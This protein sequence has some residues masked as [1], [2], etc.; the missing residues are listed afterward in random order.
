MNTKPLLTLL[1]GLVLF[2]AGWILGQLNPND[3]HA[4][5]PPPEAAPFYDPPRLYCR[6]FQVPLKGLSSAFET[7]DRTTEIGQWIE[8]EEQSY[9]LFSIDFEIGQKPTGYAE[10]WVQIC[11]SPRKS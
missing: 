1:I 11:L 3:A 2:Q 10:G 7:N 6:P 4:E 5:P 9:E 8:K